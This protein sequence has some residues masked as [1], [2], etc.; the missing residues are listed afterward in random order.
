VAR[1]GK[2]WTGVRGRGVEQ[3]KTKMP[4]RIYKLMFIYVGSVY[5]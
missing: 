4:R 5:G 2:D 3:R 1:Y